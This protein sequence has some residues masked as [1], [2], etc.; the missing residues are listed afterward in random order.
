MS[1]ELL[2]EPVPQERQ[3]PVAREQLEATGRKLAVRGIH[4][5]GRACDEK[6]STEQHPREQPRRAAAMRIFT[7]GAGHPT[8]VKEGCSLVLIVL[9]VSSHASSAQH[10]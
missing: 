2:A 3:R 5:A 7:D 10:R 4:G 8:H 9:P 6:E 1:S